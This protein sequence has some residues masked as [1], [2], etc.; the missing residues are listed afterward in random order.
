MVLQGRCIEV[1]GVMPGAVR[2]VLH[3]GCCETGDARP[4][5]RCAKDKNEHKQDNMSPAHALSSSLLRKP[6]SAHSIC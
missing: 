5:P 3:G 2:A 1:G 4:V 6:T